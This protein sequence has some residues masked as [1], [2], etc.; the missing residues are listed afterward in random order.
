[1]LFR[2]NISTSTV[3]KII[4]EF[5]SEHKDSTTKLLPD[6]CWGYA[7]SYCPYIAG[8]SCVASLLGQESSRDV[9]IYAAHPDVITA[10]ITFLQNREGI[11]D[12]GLI[13]TTSAS[14]GC[15]EFTLGK[16]TLQVIKKPYRLKDNGMYQA[17]VDLLFDYIDLGVCKVAYCPLTERFIFD[18]TE[19]FY[20]NKEFLGQF[21]LKKPITYT[22]TT[23]KE[24]T[25]CRLKKYQCRGFTL[26]EEDS[27]D[28]L[29]I[30]ASL[31]ELKKLK[32]EGMV[33]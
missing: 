23:N 14:Y 13:P 9:D 2:P 11:Q 5:W 29:S 30:W 24:S 17:D 1:M 20:P 16:E 8:G 33:S 31:Q 18:N 4:K 15:H 26:T 6:D 27:V 25:F 21:L 28:T 10:F 32:A 12:F 22:V 7:D 19:I 3:A